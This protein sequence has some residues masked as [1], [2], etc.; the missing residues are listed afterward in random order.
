MEGDKHRST[1]VNNLL[2]TLVS[3]DWFIKM[4]VLVQPITKREQFESKSD[5]NCLF[6]NTLTVTLKK[7]ECSVT[8]YQRHTHI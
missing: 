2:L 3:I 5:G 8:I 6:L 4:H 1:L 7:K